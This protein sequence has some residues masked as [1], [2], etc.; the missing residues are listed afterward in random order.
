MEAYS[1]VALGEALKNEKI[2]EMA[3]KYAVS[4]P[5]LCIRYDLQLGMITLPKTVNPEHMKTNADVD[6][7]ISNED[8]E[9]LKHIERIKDYGE[10]SRFPV[11]GGKH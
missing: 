1:P 8:M 2:G 7:V 4:I 3:E 6:F 11:F 9:V 10:H 5:Q